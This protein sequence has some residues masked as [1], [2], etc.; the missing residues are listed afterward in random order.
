MLYETTGCLFFFLANI[1][2]RRANVC[3]KCSSGAEEER[4][5][6]AASA[7]TFGEGGEGVDEASHVLADAV[8]GRG[9]QMEHTFL[10]KIAAQM[11]M[12]IKHKPHI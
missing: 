10:W 4:S 6:A 8:V 2:P 12:T 9:Y 11:L 7:L 3:R 1:L 5:A